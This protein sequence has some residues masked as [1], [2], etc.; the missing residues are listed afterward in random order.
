MG[1]GSSTNRF[2][3]GAPR[4]ADL[5]SAGEKSWEEQPSGELTVTS[6]FKLGEGDFDGFPRRLEKGGA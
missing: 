6:N 2:G 5:E 4:I 1:K 3:L